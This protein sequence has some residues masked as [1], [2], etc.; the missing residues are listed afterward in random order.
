MAGEVMNVGS[1]ESRQADN[2]R[3]WRLKKSAGPTAEDQLVAIVKAGGLSHEYFPV[4]LQ[5]RSLLRGK[6]R[7]AE[8]QVLD[9]IKRRLNLLSFAAFAFHQALAAV[10]GLAGGIKA[11]W[12]C[13]WQ[14]QRL[15]LA[16]GKWAL[17]SQEA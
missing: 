14:S 3:K 16:F 6:G 7:T 2:S 15:C 5:T 4:E 9:A 1:F 13:R 17:K 12:H 8:K 11:P 10:R